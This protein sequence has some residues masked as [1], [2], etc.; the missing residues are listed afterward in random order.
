MSAWQQ[1]VIEGPAHEAHGFV[2]GVLAD[3]GAA[4]ESA[5]WAEALGLEHVSMRER[6][7]AIL[8]HG[9]HEVFLPDP[10]ADAVATALARGG[11]TAGLSLTRR[12]LVVRAHFG[13]HAETPSREARQ[14]IRAALVE[15]LPPGAALEELH[16]DEHEDPSARGV[17]L[18]APAH[19]YAY[20]ASGRI[21]GDP[22]AVFAVWRRAR[23]TDFV[24]LDA[25]EVDTA[26][27]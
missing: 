23:G 15:A 3:A 4:P 11:A 1:L 8:G 19:E 5:E 20:R 21:T 18:Y 25:L 6:V 10:L 26:P 14:R 16:E 7:A 12:L 2:A 9:H 22:G 24:H 27:P 13:F 17:E